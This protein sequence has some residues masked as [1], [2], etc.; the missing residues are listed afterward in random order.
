MRPSRPRLRAPMTPPACGSGAGS[1]RPKEGVGS[2]F[3]WCSSRRCERRQTT[4]ADP[5]ANVAAHR[6][7]A[8]PPGRPL[9][10][11]HRRRSGR[12]PGPAWC[13]RKCL[14]TWLGRGTG[15]GSSDPLRAHGRVQVQVQGPSTRSPQPIV[16]TPCSCPP[17]GQN[18]QTSILLVGAILAVGSRDGH[19]HHRS[20]TRPAELNRSPGGETSQHSNLRSGGGGLTVGLPMRRSGVR[21]SSQAPIQR[22]FDLIGPD[23]SHHLLREPLVS[24]HEGLTPETSPRGMGTTHGKPWSGPA[25][26]TNGRLQSRGAVLIS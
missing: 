25:G 9:Q 26:P 20:A 21:S 17:R 15:T 8:R 7:F 22:W 14:R 23:P 19:H 2:Y 3:A 6:S 18:L 1:A 11:R 4:K 10:P 12:G 16:L 13:T 24:E 5:P